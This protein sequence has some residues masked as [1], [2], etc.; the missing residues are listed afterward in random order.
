MNG[1]LP[2]RSGHCSF[3]VAPNSAPVG[4]SVRYEMK[5]MK[6][7]RSLVLVAPVS[8]AVLAFLP[9][10]AAADGGGLGGELARAIWCQDMAGT[11]AGA[12]FDCNVSG[13]EEA[14]DWLDSYRRTCSR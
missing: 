6:A 13:D 7:L 8:V 9:T 12:K 4:P 10:P 11:A 14:C 2:R 3:Q 5:S 1:A